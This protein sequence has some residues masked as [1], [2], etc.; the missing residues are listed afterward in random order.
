MRHRRKEREYRSGAAAMAPSSYVH[1]KQLAFLV[2]CTE[3]RSTDSSWKATERQDEEDEKATRESDA[4]VSTGPASTPPPNPTTP[5]STPTPTAPP[6]QEPTSG[7]ANPRSQRKRPEREEDRLIDCLDA[8]AHPA[9]RLSCEALFLLSLEDKMKRVPSSRQTEVRDAI[10][11]CIDSFIPP[12]GTTHQTTAPLHAPPMHIHT[13]QTY[14][15]TPMQHHHD[16]WQPRTHSSYGYPFTNLG[17]S[18]TTTTQTQ[19][20]ACSRGMREEM[21]EDEPDFAFSQYQNL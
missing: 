5:S 2:P 20:G 19:I 9:P 8:M 14:P 12:D 3:M 11:R 10:T 21:Q 16:T 4:C 1:S 7:R 13:P 18:T 17:H 6:A 15:Q